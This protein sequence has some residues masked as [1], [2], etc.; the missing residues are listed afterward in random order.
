MRTYTH[1]ASIVVWHRTEHARTITTN[2][3]MMRNTK[4]SDRTVLEH[5]RK[6]YRDAGIPI[7]IRAV[8]RHHEDES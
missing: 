3:S 4:P 6:A 2:G 8:L 5:I 1:T 7:R